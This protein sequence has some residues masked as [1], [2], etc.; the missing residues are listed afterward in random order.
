MVQSIRLALTERDQ[1]IGSLTGI[2]GALLVSM[3]N[4]TEF[5]AFG[6]WL[7]SNI[8]WIIY[9]RRIKSPWLLM[10][11]GCYLLITVNGLIHHY[12]HV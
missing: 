12:S 4:G 1:V 5:L 10:M 3:N 2:A 6:L 11:M 9:A 7:I 8:A